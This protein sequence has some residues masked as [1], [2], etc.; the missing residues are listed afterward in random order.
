MKR[1][2]SEILCAAVAGSLFAAGYAVSAVEATVKAV[3]STA[4]TVTVKTEDGTEHTFHVTK[5]TVVHGSEG[6]GPASKDAMKDLHEGSSVVVHYT[7]KGS[8][9][10]AQ[11]IDRLGSDGLKESKGTISKLDRG[12]KKLVLKSEDGTEQTYDLSARAAND[13]GKDIAE[14]SDKGANVTVYYAEAGGK[15]VAH[16]FKKAI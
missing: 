9:E 4:R 10:T 12:G 14:G 3:D 11:E 1:L 7:K 16:F 13:A 6:A 5:R 8:D 2:L 15:K